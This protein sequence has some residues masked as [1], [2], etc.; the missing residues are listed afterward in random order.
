MNV[1]SDD[2]V[3]DDDDVDDAG[4]FDASAATVAALSPAAAAAGRHCRSA[5]HITG[6]TLSQP[7]DY[8]IYT[9]FQKKE[10]TKLLA[11]TFSNLNRFS[12][13]FHC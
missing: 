1:H 6:R 10:A 2:E 7:V 11:I 13:L 3:D 5:G 4:K 12:K 9:V 8:M